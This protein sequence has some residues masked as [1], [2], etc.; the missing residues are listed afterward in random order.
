MSISS[1]VYSKKFF[2]SHFLQVV[3]LHT[4]L[5]KPIPS[6]EP[7]VLSTGTNN[8]TNK[9]GSGKSSGKGNSKKAGPPKITFVGMKNTH[10]WTDPALFNKYSDYS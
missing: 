3:K 2:F 7:Q 1:N 9:S 8:S 5:G 10:Y 4:K 6:T